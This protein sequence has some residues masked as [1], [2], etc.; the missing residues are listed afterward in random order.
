MSP[1][2]LIIAIRLATS[3][4]VVSV[5]GPLKAEEGKYYPFKCMVGL[6]CANCPLM[7]WPMVTSD[8]IESEKYVFFSDQETQIKVIMV[9]RKP[10]S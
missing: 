8:L 9:I 7:S 10:R 3:E 6:H 4:N 1:Y 2:R 5:L